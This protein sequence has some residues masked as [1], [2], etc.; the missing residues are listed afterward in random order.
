M[1]I[2]LE[3]EKREGKGDASRRAGRVPGVV[4]GPK[5][6]PIKLSVD[7]I[8]FEKTLHDA[9][10]ATIISLEGLA[11]PLEVLIH[12][13]S[14]NAARGGVEHVDFY[15]IERGKE[16]TTNVPL[17][18]IGEAPATKAGAMVTKAL[19]ELEITCRPGDLPSHIDVDISVLVDG[20]SQ[21]KVS[22]LTIPKG[23]TVEADPE[24][25]VATVSAAREEEP[26][27]AEAAAVDMTA[28]EVEAKG[29]EEKPE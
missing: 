29:K 27:T 20:D 3:V 4:Y 19:Q 13:V 9:G 17:E 14:F 10:E 23:V 15:A 28:V 5:Q 18:F 16:L 21:I 6:E 1:T 7:A 8:T 24:W 12:D 2:K 25:V 26:E 11:E 22:D